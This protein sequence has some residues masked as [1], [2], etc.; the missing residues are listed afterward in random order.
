MIVYRVP[1]SAPALS[2]AYRRSRAVPLASATRT[3]LLAGA[4]LLG[5]LLLLSVTLY[6]ESPWKLLR[7]IGATV[8]GPTALAPE[9]Q[10]DLRI[11]S[12]ALALHFTL[13]AACA[14]ML[15]RVAA[16]L[17]RVPSAALGIAFGALLYGANVYGAAVLYPWLAELRSVDTLLAHLLFGLLATPPAE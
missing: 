7:M 16:R 11:V 13:T 17:R 8:F 2:R 4:A 10:F 15:S 5:M 6:D 1:E 3:G 9:S 12:T 14:A